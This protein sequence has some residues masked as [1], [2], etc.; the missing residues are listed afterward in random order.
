M[1]RQKSI[2][3]K[4]FI[5][6]VA[7][8]TLSVVIL[9]VALLF[10]STQHFRNER[11]DLLRKNAENAASLTVAN[12]ASNAFDFINY[13]TVHNGYRLLAVASDTEIFFTDYTGKT[14]VCSHDYSCV[15]KT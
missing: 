3:S 9:G 10:F 7:C 12:Y 8:V 2:F 4:Y 14:L 1:N 6:C 13:Q 5:I 15:H 11:Y